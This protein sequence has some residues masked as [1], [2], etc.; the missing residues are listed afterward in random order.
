L[1]YGLHKET[2]LFNRRAPINT[3]TAPP[4]TPPGTRDNLIFW[5]TRQPRVIQNQMRQPRTTT[6]TTPHLSTRDDL[7][8]GQI[9]QP[10]TRQ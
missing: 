2:M 10:N 9:S 6:T 4:P 5:H 8:F 1:P 7:I 3:I